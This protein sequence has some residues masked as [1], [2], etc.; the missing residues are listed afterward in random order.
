MAG[1]NEDKGLALLTAGLGIMGGE[2]PFAAVNIGRGA[3]MGVRQYNEATKEQRQ[4][5]QGLRA[6]DQQIAIA[7]ATRDER[8][9]EVGLKMKMDAEEGLR[10]SL[11]RQAAASDR[12]A[13][14]A[15]AAEERRA[16]REERTL[17]RAETRALRE[18]QNVITEIG[19]YQTELKSIDTIMVNP[20]L[21]DDQRRVLQGQREEA[22]QG[23]ADAGR[24]LR[25]LQGEYDKRQP[26][27][28]PN[29]GVT[30]PKPQAAGVYDPKTGKIIWK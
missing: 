20:M 30:Q 26:G 23:L 7:Q 11:D 10:R 6:A 4:A 15:E 22:Q 2:S 8:Q 17:D 3:Q 19:R 24:R 1:S 12:A 9:L 5:L 18:Q 29:T 14:R 16:A 21:T 27:R 25:S 13:A 28:D